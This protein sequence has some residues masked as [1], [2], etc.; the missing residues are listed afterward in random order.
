MRY[1]DES[2]VREDFLGFVNV[3]DLS[4]K[5][6]ASAILT[7]LSDL[8][9]D[10]EGLVGQGYDGAAAMS[11]RL[12]GVQAIISEKHPSAL[13]MH[14][15]SH[16]LNLTL[17]SSSSVAAVRNAQGIISEVTNFVNHSAK[18][19]YLLENII[20]ESVTE[21]TRKRRLKTLCPTRWAERHDSILTFFEMMPAITELLERCEA[22]NDIEI[23]TKARM[24]QKAMSDPSFIVTIC[25]LKDIL[26]VTLNLSVIL[27]KVDSDLYRAVSYIEDVIQVLS[28]RRSGVEQSFA[29][30]W[31]EAKILADKVG[32]ELIKP[33]VVKR[34]VH[35]ENIPSSSD[36]EYY[37]R[38]V[39]IQFLDHVIG[40]MK[41]R[42]EQHNAVALK[43]GILIPEVCVLQSSAALQ[44]LLDV[45]GIFVQKDQVNTEYEI[46]QQMWKSSQNR[47]KS[48]TA[49]LEKCDKQLFP[50]IHTLLRIIATIPI[51]NAS[52]ERS[53]STLK[54]LKTYLRST[55][56]EERLCSLALINVHKDL[57]I[58]PDEVIDKFALQK[59]R[60]LDFII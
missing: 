49:A 30:L 55:M 23:V 48:V 1:L 38:T 50:N 52:G 40:E 26:G 59:N 18:R 57:E 60:K 56:S 10:M 16:C 42:F 37:R 21:N 19:V 47:P 27:Q 45:Y 36:E 3:N 32:V 24:M 13:Y 22:G 41:R 6:L 17:T 11:G 20:D 51:T 15:A 14:C 29:K 9:V 33:R 35:R 44:P 4:G 58:H 54:R 25:V 8:N 53:F 34:Q 12:T 31:Q 43:I 28:N 46:W 5:G 39:Y 7:F 2:S